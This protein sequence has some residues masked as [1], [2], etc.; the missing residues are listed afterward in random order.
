MPQL[1]P[2]AAAAFVIS[3][4]MVILVTTVIVR[5]RARRRRMMLAEMVRATAPVP[6][7]AV[8]SVTPILEAPVEATPSPLRGNDY[9]RAEREARFRAFDERATTREPAPGRPARRLAAQVAHAAAATAPALMVEREHPMQATAAVEA[10]EVS[11]VA[12]SVAASIEVAAVVEESPPPPSAVAAAPPIGMQTHGGLASV[13]LELERPMLAVP[14]MPRAAAEPA[15][16]VEA[17]VDEPVVAERE[18]E[19]EPA[20]LAVPAARESPVPPRTPQALR[21]A[22]RE[23]VREEPASEPIREPQVT[24]L[25]PRK[26]A[27]AL[28]AIMTR[29]MTLGDAARALR[30][31][32][33]MTDGR[34]LRRAVAVGAATS[35]VAAAF[36]IRGRKR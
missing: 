10:P 22:I 35:V 6:R 31:G 13:I 19:Q 30:S 5:V 28:P 20:V 11:P 27:P 36:V 21:E 17:E 25:A 24:V 23:A 7:P 8:S 16:V 12:A 32:L 14:A 29:E 26:V 34:Q 1:P 18:P 33:T 2:A 15:P 9:G 3:L 4:L